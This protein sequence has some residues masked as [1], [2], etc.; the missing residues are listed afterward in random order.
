MDIRII[1]AQGGCDGQRVLRLAL[2]YMGLFS[3]VALSYFFLDRE[4]ASGLRPYTHDE[5]VF[6]WLT[7]IVNPLL[8]LASIGAAFIG[9]RAMA[10]GSL[11]QAESTL[12]RICCAILI[13]YVIKDELKLLFGRTWPET[14]V[15]NNPSYFGNPS[16][17]GFFW[18]HGGEGYKSFPSGHTTLIAT[19]AGGL[20]SL[21]PKLR[22]LGVTLVIAVAAGLLGADYHWFSDIIGGGI[23]GATTGLVAARIGR[24]Q[25]G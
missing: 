25:R 19:V 6:K 8:P 24:D 5:P 15:N 10:R 14:W 21:V 3:L 12:L 2:V 16:T 22:W 11:T 17:Y 7:Y 4:I 9:L 1:K 18:M 13:A 23:L 20:W